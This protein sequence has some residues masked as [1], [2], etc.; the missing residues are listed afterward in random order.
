MIRVLVVDDSAFVRQALS[1]ML[2]AAPD[3]EVVGTA[4][5]GKEGWEKALDLRPDVVT[6]DVKMPR[7][8]GL[9]ALR[10]IMAD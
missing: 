6:L 7:M 4:V 9:E 3:I 10:R 2:G 1:R 8:D 5:D